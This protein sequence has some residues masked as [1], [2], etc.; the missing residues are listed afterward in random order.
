MTRCV[1]PEWLDTLPPDDP[2]ALASRRDLRR[3]NAIMGNHGLTIR[4][5]KKN[6]SSAPAQLTELGAGDGNFLLRLAQKTALSW[7]D[8]NVTLIDRQEAVPSETLTSFWRLGWGAEAVVADAFDWSP[9]ASSTP[10]VV[11]A[12]LFLHH[13]ED[14]RL[15]DLLGNI[16][17]HA[18]LFIAIEPR[19]FA[20]ARLVAPFLWLLGCN[21]VTRHDAI[22][23]I[24]SGF[25]GQELSALWPERQNWRLV[26]RRAGL[27]SHMFIAQRC[28]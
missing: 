5:L 12:N 20:L 25:V 23:S 18:A 13:F 1:E 4:A 26:E 7:P 15:A 2:S 24:R 11:I 27:F 8:V 6:L 19:R 17:R 22:I 10:R 14:A 21:A 9:P 3:L 28:P 16:S